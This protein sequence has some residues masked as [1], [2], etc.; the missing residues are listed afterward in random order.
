MAEKQF[1]VLGL[2]HTEARLLTLLDRQGGEVQQDILSSQIT[3][4]RSN[5]GRAL[6]NLERKEL[7]TRTSDLADRRT[8]A[9]RITEGG[10]KLASKIGRMRKDMARTFF[11]SLDES[12]AGTILDI[13]SKAGAA[14]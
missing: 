11:G 8:K 9:V 5:A 2:N 10:R 13:L 4:D 6:Q 12:G 7:V 14:E 1:A 3:L